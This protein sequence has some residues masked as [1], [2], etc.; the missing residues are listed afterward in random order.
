M[1]LHFHCIYFTL[2]IQKIYFINKNKFYRKLIYADILVSVISL[3]SCIS[4]V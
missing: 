2:S 1:L 3:Y 4:R